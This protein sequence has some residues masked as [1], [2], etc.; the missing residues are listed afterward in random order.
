M[1]KRTAGRPPI[2]ETERKT[3]MFIVRL[4]KSQRKNLMQLSR[5]EETPPSVVLRNLLDDRSRI[6]STT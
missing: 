5:A 3:Y 1:R 4:D 2:P 6:P